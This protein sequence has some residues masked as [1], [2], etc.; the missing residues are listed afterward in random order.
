MEPVLFYGVPHGCS[1]GAIVAL[2]WLGQ[3]Y[4]LSRVEM[5]ETRD[6]AYL[7][8]NPVGATP[9]LLT[10][11]GRVINESLAILHHLASR[12]LRRPLGFAQGTAAFDDLN[13][14]LA[15]LHADFH[16]VFGVLFQPGKY[17]DDPAAQANALDKARA[18]AA[19]GYGRLEARLAERDWLAG[20]RQSVADAYFAGVARWGA[21][22]GLFDLARDFPRVHAHLRKLDADPAVAFAHAVEDAAP[23]VSAGGFLGQVTLDALKPRLAA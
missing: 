7:G 4:R 5:L 22:L 20:D 21:D 6:P 2:E 1:F 13:Y 3:P 9:A 17:V 11:D 14:V 15:F 23:A 10:A 8:V 16:P 12:D 18:K 19:L